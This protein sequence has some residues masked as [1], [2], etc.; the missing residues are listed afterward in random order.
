MSCTEPV[1]KFLK[2]CMSTPYRVVSPSS[3]SAGAAGQL[4]KFD[5]FAVLAKPTLPVSTVSSMQRLW[6]LPDEM[7]QLFSG[8]LAV[9][10]SK[11]TAVKAS[12]L[13]VQMPSVVA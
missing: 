9:E 3:A 1:S 2:K 4:T 13:P 8:S 5:W 7:F 6:L 12:A 11:V 10:S